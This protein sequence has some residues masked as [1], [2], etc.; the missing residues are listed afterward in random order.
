MKITERS[1]LM[2]QFNHSFG[3]LVLCPK[4]GNEYNH[5]GKPYITESD[6]Y[7]AWE[8]RG[9]LLSI[10]VECESF[11]KWEICFGHHKGYN[12]CFT[13]IIDDI[14]D[15]YVYFIKAEG[16]NRVKI[17]ISK[18][19]EERLKQLQIGSPFKLSLIATTPGNIELERSLHNKFSHIICDGEWFH[20][21]MELENYINTLK[22]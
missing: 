18:N 21:T 20:L 13:K 12:Y 5:F 22:A 16:L 3:G 8:G 11:H 9:D 14:P 4:C 6:N 2:L 19:P 17:G 10:P 15:S 1:N 7:T